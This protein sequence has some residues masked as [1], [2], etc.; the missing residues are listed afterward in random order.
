M[1]RPTPPFNQQE[2]AQ[3]CK[4]TRELLSLANSLHLH[5]EEAIQRALQLSFWARQLRELSRIND[6][7]AQRP[8]R[9]QRNILIGVSGVPERPRAVLTV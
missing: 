7:P 9:L 5:A 3:I 6:R 4:R 1:D 8:I 2:K